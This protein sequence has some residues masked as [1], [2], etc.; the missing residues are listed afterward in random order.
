MRRHRAVAPLM[1]AAAFAA[2]VLSGCSPQVENAAPPEV[3]TVHGPE[4]AP[5]QRVIPMG[6]PALT[7]I[8][9]SDRLAFDTAGLEQ[10]GLAE[11]LLY[12]PYLKQDIA[13]AGVPA[14]DLVTYLRLQRGD[15][16]LFVALD[17]YEVTTD[18]A[19]LLNS[20]ALIATQSR[21]RQMSIADGGPIRL[22][23]PAEPLASDL[24]QWIWSIDKLTI[25]RG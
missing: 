6:K 7:I 17:G 24:D 12:E 20:E 25:I 2:A 13:F 9:G 21:G 22:V 18:V 15:R 11:S 10:L 4:V 14:R 1:V 19:D 23:F 3:V 5:G 16:I 8:D